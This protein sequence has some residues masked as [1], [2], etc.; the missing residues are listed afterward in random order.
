MVG[1]ARRVGL[2][3][4]L[5]ELASWGMAPVR[6]ASTVQMTTC[7]DAHLRSAITS[8]GAGGAR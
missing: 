1:H 6:A 8:A 5:V 7:D 3:V 4:A 2:V